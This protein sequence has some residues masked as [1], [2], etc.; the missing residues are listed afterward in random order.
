MVKRSAASSDG[1]REKEL[2]TALSLLLGVHEVPSLRCCCGRLSASLLSGD[3][4]GESVGLSPE[5]DEDVTGTLVQSYL[6][7]IFECELPQFV[8]E[9]RVLS[10]SDRTW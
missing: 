2:N 1:L 5:I 9:N 3:Q 8:F 7:S 6:S 4:A 10:G